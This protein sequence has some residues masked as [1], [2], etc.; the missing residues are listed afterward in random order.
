MK[1]STI[2]TYRIYDPDNVKHDDPEAQALLDLI[3]N[4]MLSAFTDEIRKEVFKYNKIL[5][6][7]HLE[8]VLDLNEARKSDFKPKINRIFI[9]KSKEKIVNIV[10]NLIRDSKEEELII[11]RQKKFN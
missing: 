11:K 8:F 10:L 7:C 9:P 4:N 6:G 1:Y 5:Q 2:I 3:H